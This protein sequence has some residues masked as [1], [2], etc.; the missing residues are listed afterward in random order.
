[1]HRPALLL[2]FSLLAAP[3]AATGI[4]GAQPSPTSAFPAP[5]AEGAS[6]GWPGRSPVRFQ[7]SPYRGTWDGMPVAYV[8]FRTDTLDFVVRQEAMGYWRPR[9]DTPYSYAGSYLWHDDVELYFAAFDRPNAFL[10]S[11][12]ERPW[13]AFLATVPRTHAPLR[14]LLRIDD[15]S[16]AHTIRLLSYD[17]RVLAYDLPPRRRGEPTRSVVQ[18]FLALPEHL[19]VIGLQGPVD[20][21][22]N[23]IPDFNR[24]LLGLEPYP[25]N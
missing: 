14:P 22:A 12:H 16:S 4:I 1:M 25:P 23:A 8:R 2:V 7:T 17:T 6:S 20:Q 9:A 13:R 5:P 24:V 11:L 15:S 10:P 21:V 18:V 3:V 19:L